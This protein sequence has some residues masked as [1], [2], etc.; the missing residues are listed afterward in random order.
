[1]PN[2]GSQREP[3]EDRGDDG[4]DRERDRDLYRGGRDYDRERYPQTTGG[5]YGGGY[6][7][8]G[9]MGSP[10]PWRDDYYTRAGVGGG[11]R[12]RPSW[13][14]HGPQ[15]YTRSDARIHEDLCDRLTDDHDVDARQIEVK[16]SNGDV[17]LTGR[18]S[19]RGMKYRAEE[20][21]EQVSGVKEIDNQIRVKKN[22]N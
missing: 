22:G 14:G 10:Q 20:I 9:N 12:D 18:V 8:M 19:E 13:R 1:M 7:G 2:R 5:W 15:G 3:G 6:G 4:R 11:D 21:A 17:T 16:V